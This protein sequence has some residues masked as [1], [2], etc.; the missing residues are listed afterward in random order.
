MNKVTKFSLKTIIVLTVLMLTFSKTSAQFPARLILDA[1]DGSIIESPVTEIGK[2]YT[3]TVSGTYSMWPSNNGWGVDGAYLY[4]VPQEEIDALRWP[5]QKFLNYEIY[6]LPYWLGTDKEIPPVQI[7]GLNFKLVSRQHIGFR[8]NGNWL[9]DIGFN[10][11][12]HLYQ[13]KVMGDGKPIKFQILDSSFSIT[14]MKVTPKYDDNSGS[15]EILIEEEPNLNLCDMRLI[16]ADGKIVGV[17][18]SAAVFEYL[19]EFTGKPVNMLSEAGPEQLGIAMDGYF[20]CPDS[21]KCD[22]RVEGG[23]AWAL[24]FDRSGSMSDPFGISTKMSSLKSSAKKFLSKLSTLDEAMLITFNET[25]TENVPWTNNIAKLTGT[26]ENL[27]PEG[28]TAYFDAA[29]LGVRKTFPHKNP[30]KALI[31]LSDGED[32]ESVIT[33]S[34]LITEAKQKNIRIFTIGVNIF[35]DTEASMKRISQETGGKY[36]PANDP[37]AMDEVFR[38][39]ERDVATSEC[40]DIYFS[41]PDKVINK[42]KPYKTLINIMTFDRDGNIIRKEVEIT[43]TDSCDTE[44]DLTYIYDM[45]KVQKESDIKI[46]P[47]P[48]NISCEIDF[49]VDYPGIAELK[50]YSILGQVVLNKKLGYKDKGTHKIRVNTEKLMQGTYS[51]HISIAGFTLKSKFIV[52][53]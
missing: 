1:R 9:P 47:N 43:L 40:C 4:N 53:H 52:I 33:E 5:P 38:S 39:I 25:V 22:E 28:R 20:I 29:M 46:N 18:L 15:L 23:V 30:Y 36:Y 21:I 17:K 45:C 34:A 24:V 11:Q 35:K 31:L 41:L 12:L 8:Y 10:P 14:E 44:E 51:A 32:N 49:Y 48:T 13:V 50:I 16:C 3:I 19:N 7:P 37:D 2:S 42:E 27:T 26:I 6:T